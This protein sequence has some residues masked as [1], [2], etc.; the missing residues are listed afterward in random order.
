MDVF[1][2]ELDR[3]YKIK[4]DNTLESLEKINAFFEKW[5]GKFKPEY[6]PDL[7][8]LFYNDADTWEQNRFVSETIGDIVR[9]YPDKSAELIIKNIDVLYRENGSECLWNWQLYWSVQIL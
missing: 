6:I 5:F 7:M 1:Y 2:K 8:K 3:I 9:E 4:T